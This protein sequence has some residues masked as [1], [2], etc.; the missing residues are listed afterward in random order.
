MIIWTGYV[1]RMA[2]TKQMH[3]HFGYENSKKEIIWETKKRWENNI[4][5][6]FEKWCN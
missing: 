6:Y 2:K 1:A 3:S 4:K 5:M